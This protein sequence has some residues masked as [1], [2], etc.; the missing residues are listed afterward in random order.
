M[1][2]WLQALCRKNAES[3]R[4]K[5]LDCTLESELFRKGGLIMDSSII[6][7]VV[8]SAL[9]IIV[10]SVIVYRRKQNNA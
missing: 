10:L 9:A 1:A 3:A 4:S 8:A 7:R 6:V 5:S 2:P